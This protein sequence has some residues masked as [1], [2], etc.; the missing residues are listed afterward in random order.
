MVIP[1]R[2]GIL[3]HA[4]HV[5]WA[6]IS[7]ILPVAFGHTTGCRSPVLTLS[8]AIHVALKRSVPCSAFLRHSPFVLSCTRPL[9]GALIPKAHRSS[10]RNPIDPFSWSA[11]IARAPIIRSPN[12]TDFGSLV[13][14]VRVINPAN[15]MRLL[16]M[17]ARMLSLPVFMRV[18]REE[19]GWSVRFSFVSRCSESG[20]YG[21]LG[22][23][24]RSGPPVGS[25]RRSTRRS[26]IALP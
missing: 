15:R 6:I 16:H 7:L 25:T 4:V 14:S 12:I 23:A 19:I 13:S 5:R 24:C 1:S 3:M 17:I 26:R 22:A 11:H 18:S 10:R 21:E 20:S 9:V 8:P 2:L